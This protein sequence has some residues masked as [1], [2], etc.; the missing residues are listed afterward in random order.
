MVLRS[1]KFGA[2][3]PAI[4]PLMK[5][6]GNSW[7]SCLSAWEKVPSEKVHGTHHH[8]QSLEVPVAGDR[9]GM[10]EARKLSGFHDEPL[11]GKRRGQR[12]IRLNRAYRAIYMEAASE[13]IIIVEVIEVTKHEY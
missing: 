7:E 12:S 2:Q 4:T 5:Y 13:D 10:L 6:S 1:F 3:Q 9:I 11:K 8:H